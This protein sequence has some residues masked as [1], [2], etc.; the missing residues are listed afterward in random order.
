ML[1]KADKQ[2]PAMHVNEELAISRYLSGH[3]QNSQVS[4][5]QAALVIKVKCPLLYFVIN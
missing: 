1:T 2:Y 4:K 5:L 3:R